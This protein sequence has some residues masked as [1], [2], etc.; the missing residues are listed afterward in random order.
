MDPACAVKCRF[1]VVGDVHGQFSSMVAL[2]QRWE[3]LHR[4]R[5]DFVLQVGDLEPHRDEADLS[6]MAAP[7]KHRMLGDF[8]RVLAGEIQLPWP[9]Y[10]IG[11]NHEPYG[12]LEEH[13]HGFQLCHNL[14]YLGRAGVQRIGP[15]RI[16]ALS[17]VHR[18]E[19]YA[20]ERPMLPEWQRQR[21]HANGE[22]YHSRSKG[23]RISNKDFI[24]FTGQELGH[25]MAAAVEKDIEWELA[26]IF[27]SLCGGDHHLS[28]E[29]LM[30]LAAT[31]RPSQPEA[32]AERIVQKMK[33]AVSCD[34]ISEEHFVTFFA[35][36]LSRMKDP[37]RADLL[38]RFEALRKSTHFVDVLVTHDWPAGMV[39]TSSEMKRTRPVGNEPCRLLL[40]VVKPALMV[41]GHMHTPFRN[42]A[43]EPLVRCVAKVPSTHSIAVFEMVHGATGAGDS[44]I[45]EV[46]PCDPLP[47]PHFAEE[48]S[49]IDSDDDQ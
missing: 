19:T 16:A 21:T 10:F 29:K 6:T 31:L 33:G 25:V 34:D 13:P 43:G 49:D 23:R 15:L 22:G 20:A 44:H 38:R 28:A 2:V 30:P 4:L 9:V 37:K 26:C 24:G 11:G 8:P 32:E 46:H 42:Q 45:R 7:S 40:D 35:D 41:C 39:V 18:V 48:D 47:S 5:I 12:W 27:D 36:L 1:A 17:G 14:H 3:S